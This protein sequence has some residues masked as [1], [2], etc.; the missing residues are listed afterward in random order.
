[1]I[2][3]SSFDTINTVLLATLEPN[4]P[5][6]LRSFSHFC[7]MMLGTM[8]VVAVWLSGWASVTFVY[9]VKT[10]ERILKL[11]QGKHT[12]LVFHPKFCGNIPT[13]TPNGGIEYKWGMKKNIIFEQYL[14]LSQKW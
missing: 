7:C 14:A 13:G 6:G 10:S 3:V 9:C 11:F 4:Q 1:M 2:Q 8:H 12:I 5:T